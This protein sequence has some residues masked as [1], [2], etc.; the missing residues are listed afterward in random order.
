VAL[1]TLPTLHCLQTPLVLA[2]TIALAF[3]NGHLLQSSMDV[4]PDAVPNLPFPHFAHASVS[5]TFPFATPYSPGRHE[6][7]PDEVVTL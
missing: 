4:A 7:Q 6:K 2:P 1:A 5:L 3:P